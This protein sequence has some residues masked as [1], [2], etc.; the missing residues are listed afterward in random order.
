LCSN[1]EFHNALQIS[2][3]LNIV[4]SQPPAV[5]TF[6]MPKSHRGQR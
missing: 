4:Y 5:S 3:L 6:F 2:N 1:D